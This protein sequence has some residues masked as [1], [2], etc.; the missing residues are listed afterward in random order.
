MANVVIK[1]VDAAVAQVFWEAQDDARIF[2]H[3]DVLA[4]LCARVDWWLAYWN[5]APVCLWPVCHH[6]DGS[7]RPPEF[8]EYVGPLWDD[9]LRTRRA[10][11]WWT[12]SS[13]VQRAFLS[14]LLERYGSFS[15]ELPPG[16]D[17][18]RVIQWW[19]DAM[20]GRGHVDVQLRHTALLAR[21]A[22]PLEQALVAGFSRDRRRAVRD[23][24]ALG[25]EEWP[26]PERYAL[27]NL[28]HQLLDGKL[29]RDK[30]EARTP[31][32]LALIGIAQAGAGRI[33]AYRSATGE[34]AAFT[35]VMASPRTDLH[36]LLAASPQ[37]RRD[38]L[39]IC[40]TLRA[41][42]AG[43]E[44]GAQQVDF[45]GAN[46]PVGAREKHRYGAWPAIY[47]RI[48]VTLR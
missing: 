47:Y 13:E 18:L 27:C 16:A 4:A 45:A 33:V 17:D 41:M 23:A 15:F 6:Y 7:V 9:A 24:P 5:D 2:L 1:R 3:P 46:S 22:P 8:A 35:L 32:L 42:L 19:G 37:A 21:P 10:H 26:E 11:R 40:A 34:P 43:F 29:E 30:A 48:R 44:A 12:I 38:G 25:Y 31:E 20:A 39:H 36:L 28:Y 14:L